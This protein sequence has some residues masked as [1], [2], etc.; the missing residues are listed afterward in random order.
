MFFGLSV[1]TLSNMEMLWQEVGD[2][3]MEKGGQR[4]R[5]SE[6]TDGWR[7]ERPTC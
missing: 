7:E 6:A 5:A 3:D 4:L 1:Q 2:R